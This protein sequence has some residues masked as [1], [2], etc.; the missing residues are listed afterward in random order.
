MA[1]PRT[2]FNHTRVKNARR[3]ARVTQ[4]PG[5]GMNSITS[6]VPSGIMK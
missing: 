2:L 3:D 4:V 6:I 5:M 1:G